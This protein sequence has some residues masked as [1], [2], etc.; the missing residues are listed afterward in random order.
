M[1]WEQQARTRAIRQ[2]DREA[3]TNRPLI[4][5]VTAIDGFRE[6]VTINSPVGEAYTFSAHPFMST[7]SWIRSI[8]ESGSL[9]LTGF[10]GSSR[11]LT[12]LGYGA[13]NSTTQRE[14]YTAG[15]F[16]YR[17]LLP[18]EIE[19]TSKG[20]AQAYFGERGLLSLRGGVITAH[21][22]Q[23]K[24]E[25][26][27]SAPTHVRRLNKCTPEE[28]G[29]E[30][31]YGLVKRPNPLNVSREKWVKTV[32]Q[33]RFAREYSRSLKPGTGATS[34]LV[35]HIEGDVM[36]ELGLPKLLAMTGRQLRAQSDY[37]TL[38]GQTLTISID[39]AGNVEVSGPVD[40]TEGARVTFPTGA[41]RRDERYRE[42]LGGCSTESLLQRSSRG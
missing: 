25:S 18:G 3:L 2:Q 12:M 30:E 31:R 42:Y 40:A 27:Q 5:Q 36:D 16:H 15:R 41:Q 29:D 20:M 24:L 28:V 7:N 26:M 1:T 22:S 6:Q 39:E 13:A 17:D 32:D 35:E 9:I 8:P 10:E 4:T 38:T 19:I 21:L 11:R 23:D 14:G 33:S 34:T 37:Y